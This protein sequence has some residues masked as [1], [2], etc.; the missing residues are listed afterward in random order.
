MAQIASQKV[1]DTLNRINTHKG[2]KGVLIVN[3][4][5]M[6]ITS[7]MSNME[8][9]EY[10]QLISQFA[11]KVQL[12]IT[13]LHKEEDVSFIRIRSKHHEIMIAPDKDFSL[14]VIQNPSNE[15]SN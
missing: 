12:A 1:N 15:E 7:T 6:A 3:K 8:T 4:K 5:G 11:T 9:I 14:I 2:V 10:G 13:S